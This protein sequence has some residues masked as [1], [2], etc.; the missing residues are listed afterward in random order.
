MID[1]DAHPLVI[2][3]D[4]HKTFTIG[5]QVVQALNGVS[6]EVPEGQFIAIMGPSGSGKST[7]LYALGG[8]D[9]PSS[10][11]IEIAGYRLDSMSSEELAHFRRDTCGFVFQA[12]HLVPTLTAL[13]NAALP[14]VFSRIPTEVREDRAARLLDALGMGERLDHRPNQLSGGQ[15]QRVAIA[16]ALFNDPPLIMADEP[17]GALDSKMGRTVMT[18]L[19]KLCDRFNKTLLIVTH[20]PSV[21][22]YADRIVMLHDGKIVEDRL[23]APE[24]RYLNA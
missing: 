6:L 5:E 3:E 13:Q 7:L 4:L 17:T 12:F 15:Q 9:R 23:Q 1:H 18:M 24:E 19:R 22:S 14:G 21:A 16:R 11:A 8:L 20:D 10:G 2:A